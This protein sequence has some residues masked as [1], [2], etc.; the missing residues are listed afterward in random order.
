ML[1]YS[2]ENERP[3]GLHAVA[4]TEEDLLRFMVAYERIA[5]TRPVPKPLSTWTATA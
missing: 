2:A 4:K 3:F 5:P 1:Q